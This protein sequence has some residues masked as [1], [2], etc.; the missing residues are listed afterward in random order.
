MRRPFFISLAIGVLLLAS[1]G[2]LEN[3]QQEA[4][5]AQVRLAEASHDLVQADAK[6]RSETIG[7]QRELQQGQTDLA[8][9]R[10]Q[11]EN[12]RRQYADQRNRDPIV[13]NAIL[14]VGIILACLL[15]LI[16]CISLVS[17]LRDPAQTDA[18]LTEILVD[19]IVNNGPLLLP[20]PN[21]PAAIAVEP[22]ED[23]ATELPQAKDA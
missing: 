6:A 8:R 11:L 15:P 23:D 1:S 20:D 3:Q 18:A 21:R 13:A 2:C 16:L 19:E 10:D 7:L 14:T 12:A 4:N 5:H 22:D 9:Q 17:S